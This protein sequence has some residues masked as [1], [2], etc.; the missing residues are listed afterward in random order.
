MKIALIN[1]SP[2]PKNSISGLL[3]QRIERLI[4][5]EHEVRTSVWRHASLNDDQLAEVTGSD[6]LVLVFPLYVDGIPAH[7]MACMDAFTRYPHPGAAKPKVYAVVNCGFYEA[8][9]TEL[10]LKLVAFWAKRNGFSWGSGLGIGAGGALSVGRTPEGQFTGPNAPVEKAL[11]AFTENLLKMETGPDVFVTP[12]MPAWIYKKAAH[13]NWRRSI[14][15][16]G[17]KTSD[18]ARKLPLPDEDQ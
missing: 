1:G 3:L 5:T 9:H 7:L 13:F 16:H 17:L 6:A 2:K 8:E 10:A 14:K 12:A 11:V 4:G 15:A 18:L